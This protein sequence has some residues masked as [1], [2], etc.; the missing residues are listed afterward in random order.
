MHICYD[1]RLTSVFKK[2]INND[3]N[4]IYKILV[5][6]QKYNNDFIELP[7]EFHRIIELITFIIY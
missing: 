3:S 7:I 2:C 1:N 5:I 4:T 6:S